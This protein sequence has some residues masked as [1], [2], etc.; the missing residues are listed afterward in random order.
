MIEKENLDAVVVAGITAVHADHTLAAIK[1]G[2][3]V[4]CEKP[5]SLDVKIVGLQL[6]YTRKRIY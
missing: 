6:E 3:H 2:L 1:K 4:I 5:L